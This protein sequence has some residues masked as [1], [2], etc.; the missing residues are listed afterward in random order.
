MSGWD[1][2][3]YNTTRPPFTND[4]IDSDPAAPHTQGSLTHYFDTM[5]FGN[6]RLYGDIFPQNGNVYVPQHPESYYVRNTSF[7]QGDDLRR[8]IGL[9]HE[10]ILEYYD[11]QINYQDYDNW[12]PADQ[13]NNG[14]INEPDGF[15]DFIFFAY[16]VIGDK[17]GVVGFSGNFTG[18]AT[19]DWR[20]D[21]LPIQLDGVQIGPGFVAGGSEPAGYSG[22][23]TAGAILNHISS[24]RGL[25]H[26]AAHE[27]GH[28]Y[29]LSIPGT[30]EYFLL[31]NRQRVSYFEQVW[32]GDCGDPA[33][34]PDT[35]L[36]ISHID[37]TGAG[38]NS[39]SLQIEPADGV[40]SGSGGLGDTFKPTNQDEFAPWTT[41]NSNT[42][43]GAFTDIAVLDIREQSNDIIVD[44]T[45]NAPPGPPQNLDITNKGQNGQNVILAWDAN[46][47]PDFDHYAI[48]RGYQ[49][50]K[51]SPVNWL[52]NPVATTSATRWT[53]PVV[54]INTSAPSS[55][56]YRITAIDDAANES[57]YSNSVSTK[58]YQVPK[59]GAPQ[60]PEV[61]AL[62]Q[63]YPN[64]FNPVTE[65]SFDLPEAAQVVLKIYN[66]L[67]EEVRTLVDN[68]MEIGFHSVSWDGKDETG[69]DLPSGIYIYRFQVSSGNAA[70][71]SFVAV[72]KL[73]LLR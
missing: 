50:D 36:L 26:V 69:K 44:A 61:I 31:E 63:N 9:V 13:N 47:E 51:F 68:H 45:M 5:S 25:V 67:G 72:K 15:V 2:T 49:D 62:H 71:N 4:F 38:I 23:Y 64:P 46:T 19:I 24:L 28:Y 42:R 10:E 7:S 29:R 54:K 32:N 20:Q 8:G 55:V 35:G 60:L 1:Y 66:V 3:I 56:H 34:L 18:I 65:I 12:D 27:F 6:F 17:S 73:T 33:G 59:I 53:D 22:G 37:S 58:S 16:R 70:A 30:S 41:P 43:N 48:Y 52:S 40:F 57:D 11:N 21:Q 14:I 39:F